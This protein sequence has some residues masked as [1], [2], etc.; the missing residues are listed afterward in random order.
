M[1]DIELQ[2]K[3]FDSGEKYPKTKILAL[4]K[5]KYGYRKFT[6][7]NFFDQTGKQGTP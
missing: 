2:V 7:N 5:T 3:S 6:Q 4:M 1:E